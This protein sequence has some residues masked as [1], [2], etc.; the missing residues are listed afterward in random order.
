MVQVVPRKGDVDRNSLPDASSATRCASSPARG[1]WIEICNQSTV[2]GYVY[3]VP[4]KGDV[5]RNLYDDAGNRIRQRVVP[6]KGDVDRN[7]L[8]G[9]AG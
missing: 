9:G 1:T 7:D 6:R 3:V 4:R 2:G 5:D 8:I